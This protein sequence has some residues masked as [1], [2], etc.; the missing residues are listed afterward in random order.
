MSCSS[1]WPAGECILYRAACGR[2]C[3]Q[4]LWVSPSPGVDMTSPLYP[5]LVQCHPSSPAHDGLLLRRVRW[6][7]TCVQCTVCTSTGHRF[8]VPSEWRGN[9]SKEPFQ[10]AQTVD[11]LARNT[12]AVT[13]PGADRDRRCLTSVFTGNRL[14]RYATTVLLCQFFSPWYFYR[15]YEFY[16]PFFFISRAL[17][18]I[19]NNLKCE[20]FCQ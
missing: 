11:V 3:T 15:Y 20:G 8:N 4:R 18:I 5:C 7:F 6:D 1:R 16:K 9:L 19:Y 12:P 17:F 14:N 2:W 13:H 10:R